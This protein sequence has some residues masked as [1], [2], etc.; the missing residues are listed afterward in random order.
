MAVY[1]TQ[2]PSLYIGNVSKNCHTAKWPGYTKSLEDFIKDLFHILEIG[3]IETVDLVKNDKNS[4]KFKAFIHFKCW[5]NTKTA[6]NMLNDLKENQKQVKLIYDEPK[7][8]ILKIN[9]SKHNQKIK[10]LENKISTLNLQ[11]E[12]NTKQ[13]NELMELLNLNN[14]SGKRKRIVD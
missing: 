6:N 4:N 12:N 9:T 3:E 11:C 5:Y 7:C 13:I 2:N 14:N 10:Y 8:W 1:Q